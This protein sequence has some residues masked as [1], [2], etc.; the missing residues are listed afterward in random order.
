[1]FLTELH[2]TENLLVI[3]ALEQGRLKVWTN[4]V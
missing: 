3:L 4:G 2:L 1:M